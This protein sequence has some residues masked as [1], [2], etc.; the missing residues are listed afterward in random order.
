MRKKIGKK[1]VFLMDVDPYDQ[2]C[3]VILNGK[4]GDFIE[5]MN[6]LKG[7]SH[8]YK[9]TFKHIEENKNDYDLE[10]K[11]KKG[12]AFLYTKLPHGYVMMINHEDSWIETVSNVAH[13]TTH[14]VHYVLDRA[15]FTLSR[16]S[17]EAFT[18]L[19]GNLIKK[20]LIQIY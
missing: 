13:E 14:L 4:F 12:C 20:I 6:T 3:V 15:G 1:K 11:P 2:Q 7:K 18:Y 9:E 5:Y 17:E 10:H 8:N 19:L 16:D